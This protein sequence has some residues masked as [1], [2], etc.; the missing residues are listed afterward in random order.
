MAFSI[1]GMGFAAFGMLTP[2]AGAILQELIDVVAVLNAL[3][4]AFSPKVKH[5][6]L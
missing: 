5:H 1:F 6:S 4:T 2:L 3:R